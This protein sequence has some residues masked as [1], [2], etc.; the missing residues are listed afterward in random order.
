M[1]RSEIHEMKIDMLAENNKFL[2]EPKSF[3]GEYSN[4]TKLFNFRL[5]SNKFLSFGVIAG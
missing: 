2:V 5:L 4:M 1:L 3:L